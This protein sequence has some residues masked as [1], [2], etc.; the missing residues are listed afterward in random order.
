MLIWSFRYTW[1]PE[2]HSRATHSIYVYI[3]VLRGEFDFC[4]ETP[5]SLHKCRAVIG[6]WPWTHFSISVTAFFRP[7]VVMRISEWETLGKVCMASDR[8]LP[9]GNQ[10]NL[11]NIIYKFRCLY[12]I[13][14]WVFI[15][16]SLIII[17][18]QLCT[19]WYNYSIK[20][21][22]YIRLIN[23]YQ[24]FKNKL[25]DQNVFYDHLKQTQLCLLNNSVY[26]RI[27]V[28]RVCFSCR[29]G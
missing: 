20:K 14:I 17:T 26:C 29:A 4:Y 19:V 11:Y 7:P 16:F 18:F 28:D 1:M 21:F 25:L 13:F 10:K 15:H 2:A 24:A 22:V 23:Y 12:I 3:H 9:S 27:L 6:F 8:V 5:W